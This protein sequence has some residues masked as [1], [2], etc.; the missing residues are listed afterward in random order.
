M[1]DY[2]K[3]AAMD[4]FIACKHQRHLTELAMLR[5]AR[6]VT[7]SETERNQ[8]WSQSRINQLTGEDLVTANFM[9]QDHF[10]FRP[11]FKLTLVGNHTPRLETVNEATRRRF[12]IV[13]FLYKPIEPDKALGAKL[14]G[15]YPAILRWMIEGCLDW[16]KHGLIRPEVVTATTNQYFEEQDLLGRWI[17]EKCETG[18]GMKATAS[19]LY[20]SWKDFAEANGESPGTATAFG[21][22]LQQRNFQKKKSGVIQYI[23]I[24]LKSVLSR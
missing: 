12:I 19:A 20:E 10:T 21:S 13:P 23:G 4:T 18:I 17:E 3:A 1:A 16:Q 7:A 14:R 24:R 8:A 11:Q 15:E 5:G 9:R 2:A 22:S 6:L